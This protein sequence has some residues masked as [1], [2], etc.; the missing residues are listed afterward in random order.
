MH[1]D[2]IDRTYSTHGRIDDLVYNCVGKPEH[3][4]VLWRLGLR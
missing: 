3:K 2:K 4:M 1:E